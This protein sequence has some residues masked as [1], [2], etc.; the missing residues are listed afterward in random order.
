MIGPGDV[1]RLTPDGESWLDPELLRI[2]DEAWIGWQDPRGGIWIADV[3]LLD[4]T[5]AGRPRQV[6][7]SAAPLAR[8]YNGPE[9]GLDINGL[10]L[11][12]T[13]LVGG[14]EQVARTDLS[15]TTAVLTKGDAHFSP[16][17]TR[18]AGDAS[19]RLL[20][21]RRPPDWGTLVWVD[22]IDTTTQHDLSHLAEREHGDARW[23][24]GTAVFVT[25]AHPDHPG[26]I[27]L[28]DTRRDSVSVITDTIEARTSPYAWRAPESADGEFL[29]LAVIGDKRLQIWAPDAERGWRSYVTLESPSIEH[30]YIGSPEPFVAGGRS[31]VSLTV[32][33]TIE[34]RPGVTDAQVWIVGIDPNSQFRQRCDDAAVGPTMRADPETLAGATQ[35]FVYYY[36][37]KQTSSEAWRCASG[38]YF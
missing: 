29:V 10:A 3:D 17:P 35:V 30:P 27:S 38:I 23:A 18:N 1:T 24:E 11:Y 25:N 34:L 12:Y 14:I 15:G 32:R 5:V 26:Q 28:V 22:A 6:G 36:V 20:M 8:T 37:V 7:A 16:L 31:Y 33:D 4:G 21:L 9:F 2:K 19:T 13:Q